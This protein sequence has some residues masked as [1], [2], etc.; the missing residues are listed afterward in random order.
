MRRRGLLL[1]ALLLAAAAWGGLPRGREMGDMAL[2]RTLGVDREG[3]DYVVT[4]STG[5]RARGLQGEETLEPMVLS[6]RGGTLSG[7]LAAMEGLS[8]QELFFGY[9]DQLLLGESLTEGGALPVLERFARDGELGLG[10]RLWLIRGSAGAAVGSGG[11]EGAAARLST[12]A[13]DG[14][15]G[16]GALPRT[17]GETLTGL[18][19]SGCACV[20]ALAMDESGLL[21][22]RG[23][24]V[25][26]SGGLPGWLEGDAARGLELLEGQGTGTV[27]LSAGRAVQVAD[28]RLLWM[29][30]VENGRIAGAELICRLTARLEEG[31]FDPT[32]RELKQAEG[33]L[34]A[35]GSRCARAALDGLRG[36]GADC[37]S[38]ERK[39]AALRPL[40]GDTRGRF[41]GWE[42]AVE[43][44]ANVTRGE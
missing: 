22:E 38:L 13:E 39:L 14:R 30:Q 9:V 1:A 11:Q 41:A 8:E 27:E 26:S 35:W 34:S 5:R 40:A 12:L 29:P 17:V 33:E 44:R 42:L 21:L 15:L 23:Y 20:P 2:L 32:D 18:L 24:G 19:E 37:L 43:T 10:A 3:E 25:L 36:M 31:A 7:A 28:V 16:R 6:A 4:A